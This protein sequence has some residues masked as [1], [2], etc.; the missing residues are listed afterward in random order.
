M[1]CGH[2]AHD[3]HTPGT[4]QKRGFQRATRRWKAFNSYFK[5]VL[6]KKYLRTSG[7]LQAHVLQNEFLSEISRNPK[8]SAFGVCLVCAD[9]VPD[10]RTSFLSLWC[11]NM[12]FCGSN[13]GSRLFLRQ[14]LK[15]LVR[16]QILA[17]TRGGLVIKQDSVPLFVEYRLYLYKIPLELFPSFLVVAFLVTFNNASTFLSFTICDQR[18]N[19]C[20]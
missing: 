15:I 8:I 2:Q 5:M 3:L 14:K 13:A 20:I 10:V 11:H 4:R 19:M 17:P 18:S 7:T 6:S 9:H 1:M 12:A 16:A